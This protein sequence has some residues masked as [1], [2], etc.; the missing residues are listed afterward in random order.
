MVE[1]K[2]LIRLFRPAGWKARLYLRLKLKICPLLALEN[3]IPDRGRIV[4]LGCG[5]GLFAFILKLG[6]P[7]REII[8]LD[9]DEKKLSLAKKI[10]L[11]KPLCQFFLSDL[12]QLDFP[13]ADIY[14]LID[15]LY[16]L[17]PSLQLEILKRCYE[18]LPRGGYIL[19]K[20]IDTR[21]RWKYLWN[22]FQETLSVR[23]IGFTRGQSFYFRS[24]NEWASLLK[25]IGFAVQIVPFHKGYC[26]SHVLIIG[27]K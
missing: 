16:L 23:I 10:Q 2:D 19:I 25:E 17:P 1:K 26:Y 24:S 7:L 20:E 21:P 22:Y 14:T 3:Y 15:V 11:N 4:D 8:G 18:L 13:S 6:S 5:N 9:F 12:N 27:Q